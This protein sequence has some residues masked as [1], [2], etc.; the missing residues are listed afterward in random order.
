MCAHNLGHFPGTHVCQSLQ[1]VHFQYTRLTV[2]QFY[3]I[4]LLRKNPTLITFG[5][6]RTFPSITFLTPEGRVGQ[7]RGQWGVWAPPVWG[8]RLDVPVQRRGLC[9][10][11][12][13]GR[14]SV[15]CL[16]PALHLQICFSNTCACAGPSPKS[17]TGVLTPRISEWDLTWRQS[18]YRGNQI[19]VKSLG[20]PGEGSRRVERGLRGLVEDTVIVTS[21]LSVL[22]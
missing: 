21:L 7:R 12:H 10:A 15:G 22:L 8:G 20:G 19:K 13:T 14:A 16:P 1:T 6:S 17:H 11:P 5:E 18:L 9:S 3:L 4:G 2:H